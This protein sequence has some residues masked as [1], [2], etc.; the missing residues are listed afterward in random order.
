M[1]DRIVSMFLSMGP[2]EGK[3]VR[4]RVLGMMF[5]CR[6]RLDSGLFRRRLML[7]NQSLNRR[8]LVRYSAL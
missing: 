4:R 6:F 1:L 7:A 2:E 8:G 5:K 3:F